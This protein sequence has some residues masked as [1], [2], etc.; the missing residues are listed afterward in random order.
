MEITANLNQLNL[1]LSD[2]ERY[3]STMEALSEQIASQDRSSP[4]LKTA[5]KKMQNSY[6]G[7]QQLKTVLG[8]AVMEYSNTE[9]RLCNSSY[10]VQQIKAPSG[11]DGDPESSKNSNPFPWEKMIM[12][13]VGSAGVVGQLA[14]VGISCAD[15]DGWGIAKGIAKL[16]GGVA[17]LADDAT[18]GW[19]GWFGFKSAGS[20]ATSGALQSQLDKYKISGDQSMPKNV[21]AVAKWAG[22][23]ITVVE[24][25]A[26]NFNEFKDS[27][28]WANP[29]MYAETAVE[30]TFKIGSGFIIGTVVTAVVGTPVG[31]AAFG[32]G[33]A[34]VAVTVVANWAL[35]ELS[36]LITGNA[37]GWVENVSDVIIDGA[38]AVGNCA[39]QAIGSVAKWWNRLWS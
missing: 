12:E 6:E 29:R 15:G 9:N 32:V 19:W 10:G 7:I 14:N 24:T 33:A 21:A 36:S 26:D 34:T 38:K 17:K 27:G 23:I 22:D 16:V 5:Y 13:A 30:S 28:G 20:E 1:L 35:D 25:G 39:K 8:S 18:A 11:R 31:W 37:E 4:L 3:A 2:F